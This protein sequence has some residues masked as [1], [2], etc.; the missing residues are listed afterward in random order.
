MLHRPML[1]VLKTVT[2]LSQ[3]HTVIF[4]RSNMVG[5]YCIAHLGIVMGQY[6]RW[7]L[8]TNSSKNA[9]DHIF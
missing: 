1:L 5:K 4:Q 8:F 3:N 2:P 6:S 9:I 7:V